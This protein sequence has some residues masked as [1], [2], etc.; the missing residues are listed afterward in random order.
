[1]PKSLPP[2]RDPKK[3]VTP[4]AIDLDTVDAAIARGVA[5]LEKMYPPDIDLG[6]ASYA[7]HG[8]SS[9]YADFTLPGQ[10]A[11]MTTAMLAC[12]ESYQASWMQRH[13]NW[14]LCYDSPNTYDRAMRLLTLGQLPRKKFAPWVRR[15]ANWIVDTAGAQGN[16]EAS[17]VGPRSQGFGDNANGQYA[18]LGLW[19][20]AEQGAEI[21][22]ALFQKVDSYWRGG[23][24]PPGAPGEGGWAVTSSLAL[25]KGANLKDFSNQVNASMTAGG[26]LSLYLT[27]SVLYG[28]K[29]VD[30]GN[31]LS[32]DLLRGVQW[33]DDNFSVEKLDGD[34]DFYY[35]AW[36]IQN[37][38]NATGYRTFNNVDWFRASTAKL[39]NLQGPDG[40]W[41][42]PKGAH[43]ST[44]F[45]LMYLQRARG[46]LA[47]CKVRFDPT[48]TPGK[49][50]SS[51]KAKKPPT[52]KDLAKQNA[53][54]NRPN[55]MYNFVTDVGRR[56][57]V[58]TSWQ[59]ADLDQPVYELAESQL[60]Y[61]ATDKKFKLTSDQ[62]ERLKEYIDAGGLLV[63]VPEGHNTGTPLMS[64]KALA[65]ELCPGVEPARVTDKQHPF[66]NLISKVESIIPF[67]LYQTSIRP[68]VVIV[69]KDIGRDLQ[70][71]KRG[72]KDRDAFNFLTNVYLYVAGKDAKRPRISNN[73]VV[74]KNETPKYAVRATRVV[75]GEDSEL[76]PQAFP[77][78]K[79]YLANRHDVNLIVV[80][81]SPK[82]LSADTK[83]AFLQISGATKLSAEQGKALRAWADAGGT[84]WVDAVGGSPEA[85]ANL[86]V[87]MK[88]LG[89][90]ASDLKPIVKTELST[91]SGQT[92]RVYQTSATGRPSIGAKF[93]DNRPAVV[94]VR[95]DLTCGLAGLNHWNIAG[96]TPSAARQVVASSVMRF[97]PRASTQPTTAPTTAPT[98][99]TRPTSQPATKPVAVVRG[100]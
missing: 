75:V 76:E 96:L 78:L 38:G 79:A 64:M 58:P 63:C 61:L 46:P 19:S 98:T 20:A 45:A 21:P 71:N 97:V 5:A 40:S 70:A 67:T 92:W 81:A 77:Q 55:D 51:A 74:Q 54:D 87:C 100:R 48:A 37:V 62:I 35:Y 66:F 22:T 2:A 4:D 93:L 32:P 39:I 9:G 10:G 82:E 33:L 88:E 86:N 26:V 60:L 30:V 28:P 73:Y 50:V 13:I 36:T 25:K 1:V 49:P 23:Q 7:A 72:P 29:R 69:E 44:S 94:V 6:P 85:L 68:R 90:A 14:V 34:F 8:L 17:N 42:G 41:P 15:D 99:T 65:A 27:E 53:W 83:L 31:S 11:L 24:R 47:I 84:L 95:G 52:A 89:L 91:G 80:K 3:P 59:I 57:E 16:W 18:L 12:G 56:M 43:V